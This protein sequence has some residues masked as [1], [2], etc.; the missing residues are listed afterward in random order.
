MEPIIF[1][2]EELDIIF[3]ALKLLYIQELSDQKSVEIWNLI[4][5]ADH[6]NTLVK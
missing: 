4:L 1:E 5:K 2:S 3:K 6:N